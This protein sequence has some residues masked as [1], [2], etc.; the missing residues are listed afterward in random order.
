MSNLIESGVATGGETV[1]ANKV[2]AELQ[3][4]CYKAYEELQ[5]AAKLDNAAEACTEISEK[6]AE[7]VHLACVELV[8]N[9]K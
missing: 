3:L 4:K 5:A 6:I 8:N 2:L 9:M 7:E 1:I